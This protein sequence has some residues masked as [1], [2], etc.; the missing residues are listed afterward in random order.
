[1]NMTLGQLEAPQPGAALVRSMQCLE[2]L[3]LGP[4]RWAAQEQKKALIETGGNE[5]G[6]QDGF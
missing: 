1:M 3:Q 2:E 4:R 5:C 6:E